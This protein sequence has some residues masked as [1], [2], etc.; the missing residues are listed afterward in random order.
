M[1]MPDDSL[2]LLNIYEVD[3]EDGPKHLVGFLDPVRAGAEGID[4]RF[5]VGEF[6]PRPDGEF[7][8]ETF[9]A[10]PEFI[11]AFTDYMNDAP[12]RAPD[13]VESAATITSDWLYIVD[14]RNAT[15]AD[16]DPPTADILGAF[17]VDDG[18]QVVPNSFQYNAEHQW[19]SP[20]HG[21]S[22]ML[23]DRRFHDWLH[24]S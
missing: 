24:A 15:E 1:S 14:P 22:A 16:Q 19:F 2:S 18:G 9:A 8:V 20:D 6:T 4:S 10:N 23:Q 7:D 13:V 5:M 3:S 11:A 21:I 17:A 12:S